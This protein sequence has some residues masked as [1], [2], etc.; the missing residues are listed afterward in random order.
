M[1]FG[2]ALREAPLYAVPFIEREDTP[3][4]L[5]LTLPN[6]HLANLLDVPR[7]ITLIPLG[8]P[9]SSKFFEMGE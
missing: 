9:I 7:Q 8:R 4:S 1:H 2:G 3:P 5:C 6:A